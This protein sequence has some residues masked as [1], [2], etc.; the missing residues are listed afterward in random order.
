MERPLSTDSEQTGALDGS[1]S[2]TTVTSS[3]SEHFQSGDHADEEG[4]LA[5]ATGVDIK[6]TKGTHREDFHEPM[7]PQGITERT[8]C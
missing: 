6:A 2:L 3:A 1:K 8:E 7:S 4:K 5:T